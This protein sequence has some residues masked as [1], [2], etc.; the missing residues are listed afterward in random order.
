MQASTGIGLLTSPN[1][2]TKPGQGDA[3]SKGD[4]NPR[5]NSCLDHSEARS[6]SSPG[7]DCPRPLQ[8]DSIE[9]LTLTPSEPESGNPS[10]KL[11]LV[12]D[13]KYAGFT[14]APGTYSLSVR[15]LG[16]WSFVMLLQQGYPTRIR[17]RMKARSE[18][19]GSSA[20]FLQRAGRHAC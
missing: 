11:Y 1:P 17:V 16:K 3:S 15:E 18:S 13:V 19:H 10:W 20:L 9:L 6:L 2:P 7:G 5:T 4:L 8:R 14:L 12:F